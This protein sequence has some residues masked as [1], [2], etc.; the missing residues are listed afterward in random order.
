MSGSIDDILAHPVIAAV[1]DEASFDRALD[2]HVRT[3][4]LMSGDIVSLEHSADRAR[5]SR[6]AILVHIDLVRGLASDREGVE[7]LARTVRPDGIVTNR[8][9]L[10]R[11]AQQSGLL[12]VQHLFVIDTQ[13]L[14]T[15]LRHVEECSADAV[16]LMPGLMPRVIREVVDSVDR[17]VLAAGLIASF[18]EVEQAMGAGARAVVASAQELWN[19]ELR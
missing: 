5:H 13:A 1:R 8:V 9:Q 4:F 14:A 15:G 10:L 6:K 18:A 12:A 7:Y 19:L 17:P 3:I 11:A 16:E 2:S